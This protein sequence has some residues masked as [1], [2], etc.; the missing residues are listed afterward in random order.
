MEAELYGTEL[1]D[2]EVMDLNLCGP[3]LYDVV[4]P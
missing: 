4:Q 2:P 3:D 1:Y